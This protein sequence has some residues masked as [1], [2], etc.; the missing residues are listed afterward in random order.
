MPVRE[1]VTAGTLDVRFLGTT[2]LAFSDGSDTVVI[3]GFVTRPDA[4][5]LVFSRISSD[6]RLVRRHLAAAGLSRVRAVL[7]AHTHFDHALDAPTIARLY[8]ATLHGTDSLAILAAASGY[9]GPTVRLRPGRSIAVGRFT[10]TPHPMP[11]SPGGVAGG[12]VPPGFRS[13]AHAL[14]WRE[15]G[16][17]AF[18]VEHGACRMLVVPSAGQAAGTFA[19]VSADVVFLGIGRL[20]RQT[21]DQVTA[22]WEE[23]IGFTGARLVI[24][25]HWDDFT[26]PLDTPLVAMPYLLDRVD[27]S[28]E[29]L[30]AWAPPDVAVQLPVPLLPL[31]L[32][33][34]A[35]RCA[36]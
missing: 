26:R 33:S 35:G 24:P 17:H 36:M 8:G 16:N 9:G 21:G 20:A 12:P 11:H 28:L 6:E 1:V 5:A 32:G 15:G 13:P 7:V 23:T 4:R 3:D 25:I 19:G 34:H 29:A 18:L 30:E 22:Y 10:V 31:G 14:A 2:G 27:R